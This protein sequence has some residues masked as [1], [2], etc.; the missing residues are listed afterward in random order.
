MKINPEVEAEHYYK[1]SDRKT[2]LAGAKTRLM[3]VEIKDDDGN[4]TGHKLVSDVD[5][6]REREKEIVVQE[7]ARHGRIGAAARAAGVTISTVKK[8]VGKDANFA[9]CVAEAIEVYRDKLI[10]HHQRLV[11]EGEQKRTYDREG[12]LIS[13]ETRYPVRLIELEL[14]KHDAGYREKQEI[15]HEHKGGVVVAPAELRDVDE[16]ERKFGQRN[17]PVEDAEIVEDK[18]EDSGS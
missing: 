9:E 2:T 15:S 13:V 8:H 10:N 17:E 7:L 16:W 14:K 18:I 5:K 1:N 12:N 3:V 4:V 6:F 11:F